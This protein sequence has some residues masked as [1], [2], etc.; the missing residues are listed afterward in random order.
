MAEQVSDGERMS[1]DIL[2]D[3]IDPNPRQ[4]RRHFDPEKLRELAESIRS[5]GL[6]QPIMVRPKD[7]RYEIDG[8][9][10]GCDRSS[11]P[12]GLRVLDQ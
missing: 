8:A 6:I 10:P 4:A 1:Q 9:D 3:N 12:P 5:V 11:R 7:G 2:V